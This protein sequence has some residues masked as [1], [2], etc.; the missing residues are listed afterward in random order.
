MIQFLFV[1]GMGHGWLDPAKEIT[2]NR[3]IIYRAANG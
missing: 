1:Y 2:G 3:I